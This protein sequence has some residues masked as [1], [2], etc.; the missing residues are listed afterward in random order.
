[1]IAWHRDRTSW[2]DGNKRKS[3]VDAVNK[4]D[5]RSS[6]TVEVPLRKGGKNGSV[7]ILIKVGRREPD[8]IG[9]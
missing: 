3:R 8:G 6:V 1:M 4:E 5:M 2:E 9:T 7:R